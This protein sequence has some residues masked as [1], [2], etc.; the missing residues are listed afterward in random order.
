MNNF[1][2]IIITILTVGYGDY[3][4]I[5]NMGRF[6]IVIASFW[7]VF[8]LSLFVAILDNSFAF[9]SSEVKSFDILVRLQ[10]KDKIR[11]VAASILGSVYRI[12]KISKLN[13]QR[14]VPDP[15]LEER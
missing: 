14:N 9:T 2:T 13:A 7:G 10:H 3:Y 1:Y 15:H 6:V 11:D 5:S 4:P 12:K 8:L